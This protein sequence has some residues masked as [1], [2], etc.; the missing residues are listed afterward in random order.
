MPSNLQSK[1]SLKSQEELNRMDNLEL[2]E[3]KVIEELENLEHEDVDSP[4]IYGDS[5]EP[6]NPHNKPNKDYLKDSI[7]S[8]GHREKGPEFYKEQFA[9]FNLNYDFES[10]SYVD[11]EEINPIFLQVPSEQDIYKFC[12]KIMI[13]SKMEHEIPI[14]ALLYIEKLM[15]KTGLLMN[16]VNWRRFTFIALVIASKIWD[17]ESFENIHFTKVFPDISLKEINELERIYLE[18]LEYHMHI[19]G[20]EYAKY[21]FILR[22]FAEKVKGKFP[23]KPIPLSKIL[24]PMYSALIPVSYTHLTLPTNREV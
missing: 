23:L 11:F 10:D 5:L 9:V 2:E 15:L 4:T 16:Q 22:A 24:S 1:K 14:I 18:L 17:D 12:K 21:Y 19:C 6:A 7:E 3:Q 8:E 20:S 13:C